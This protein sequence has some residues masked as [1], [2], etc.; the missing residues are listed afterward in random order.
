MLKKISALAAGASL[1]AMATVVPA[2][3]QEEAT[4]DV[5]IDSFLE[6]AINNT[7]ADCTTTPL[8]DCPFGS[9]GETSETSLDNT[10]GF[11]GADSAA[12]TVLRLRTN[13][14]D[15]AEVVAFATNGGADN[16]ECLVTSGGDVI[17]D[18]AATAAGD[19]IANTTTDPD[20]NSITGLSFRLTSTGTSTE[21]YGAGDEVTMWGSDDTV[22]NA[23]WASFPMLLGNAVNI[24]DT[25][26][27]QTSDVLANITYFIGVDA[28]QAAGDY[29][30]TANYQAS[31]L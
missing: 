1:I 10:S 2:M 7:S 11:A 28:G 16:D 3:A 22:P 9:N 8:G 12:D 21:L 18:L 25:A 17:P 5:S 31:V 20:G 4:T 13:N 14:T 29:S 27:E 30:C 23:L 24:Y 15:G 19:G 6:F 26:T